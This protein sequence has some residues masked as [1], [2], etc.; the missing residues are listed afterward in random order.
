MKRE[1]QIEDIKCPT[2][3]KGLQSEQ[4]LDEHHRIEHGMPQGGQS[5]SDGGR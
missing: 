1:G 4:Q 3:G 5:M 2:C